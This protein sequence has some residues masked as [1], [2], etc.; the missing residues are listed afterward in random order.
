MI[1][2]L[3]KA[4]CGRDGT[5]CVFNNLQG[6]VPKETVCMFLQARGSEVWNVHTCV[7]GDLKNL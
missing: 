2:F 4:C 1:K 6:R 5:W 7:V 3:H